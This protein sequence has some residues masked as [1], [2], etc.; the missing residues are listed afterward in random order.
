MKN[1][2]LYWSLRSVPGAAHANPLY[3]ETCGQRLARFYAGVLA[4]SAAAARIFSQACS[5]CLRSVC[6]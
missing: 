5:T 3:H 4:S 6:D 1:P 2:V